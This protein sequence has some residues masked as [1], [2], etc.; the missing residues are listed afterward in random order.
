MKK[1]FYVLGSLLILLACQQPSPP[2]QAFNQTQALTLFQQQLEES[3]DFFEKRW[4]LE[5]LERIRQGDTSLLSE[6]LRDQ[7][8]RQL[9]D[10]SQVRYYAA[11]QTFDFDLPNPL[12]TVEAF[13]LTLTRAF[14]QDREIVLTLEK[15]PAGIWLTAQDV[16]IQNHDPQFRLDKLEFTVKRLKKKQLSTRDWEQFLRLAEEN[17]YWDLQE[18]NYDE[19]LDGSRWVLEAVKSPQDTY[20][21]PTHN[22]KTLSRW[23]PKPYSAIWKLGQHLLVLSGEDF[24]KIY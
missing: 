10:S 15:R 2:P 4:L 14:E 13:R 11:L 20:G 19:G 21:P 9:F 23:A 12:D 17:E 24:G 1:V 18:H 7:A 6:G 8:A 3:S 5:S 22:R 16:A